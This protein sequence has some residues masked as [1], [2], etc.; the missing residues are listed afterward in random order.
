[1]S[2]QY[3]GQE[4]FSEHELCELCNLHLVQRACHDLAQVAIGTKSSLNQV[5]VRHIRFEVLNA[6]RDGDNHGV[7]VHVLVVLLAFIIL[8]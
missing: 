3:V 4:L 5:H 2:F 1:M 8:V 6:S 7:L